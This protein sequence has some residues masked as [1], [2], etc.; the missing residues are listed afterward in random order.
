[1]SRIWV[2]NIVIGNPPEAVSLSEAV[3]LAGTGARH[4]RCSRCCGLRVRLRHLESQSEIHRWRQWSRTPN[5]WE[6]NEESTEITKNIKKQKQ[7][8]LWSY[9]SCTATPPLR[10]RE[11][12]FIYGMQISQVFSLRQFAM[13]A[14]EHTSN[15]NSRGAWHHCHRRKGLCLDLWPKIRDP[16]ICKI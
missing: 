1:M 5:S 13:F 15:L 9:P 11:V 14:S 8:R 10:L 2:T 4:L 3:R 7:K 6:N 12:W 16:K